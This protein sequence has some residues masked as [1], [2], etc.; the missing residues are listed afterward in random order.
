M[1]WINIV[2][3][4]LLLLCL[5]P[6]PYGY[7]QLV[8]LLATIA[9]AVMAFRYYKQRIMWL[10]Y[11]FGVLALMFQPFYKIA[12][13]R[14]MW[15]IV[16]VIVAVGLTILFFYHRRRDNSIQMEVVV[17]P[18]K[19]LETSVESR[20]VRFTLQGKLGPHDLVYVASE[21][22]KELDNWFETHLK[23]FDRLELACGMHI[24][25]LPVLMRQLQEQSVLRYRAPYLN[26]VEVSRLT[27]GNDF[28]LQ[29]LENPEEKGELIHGLLCA[30]SIH[31]RGDG[32]DWTTNRFYPLSSMSDVPIEQQ[33]NSILSQIWRE[34]SYVSQEVSERYCRR[35]NIKNLEVQS[36]SSREKRHLE[37]TGYEPEIE[38]EVSCQYR[39]VKDEDYADNTFNS[40]KE[41]ENTDDLM[42]EIKVRV[43]KLRQRG[44][45]ES[46]LE[47]LLHPD[48]S[49]RRMVITRGYQIMLPDFNNMEIMMEPLVK[50]VYLLFLHHPEGIKFKDLP[51]YRAELTQ[52]YQQLKPGGLTDRAR[53]S[54]EDV[55][56]PLQNSINEK[57]ARIRGAFLREFD[58][59]IA[60]YYYIDGM[61][62]EAKKIALPRELV[63]WE[64]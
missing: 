46:I 33:V 24:V 13:G 40:Q 25:Y 38:D 56:N 34:I 44:I 20:K 16:D 27:V 37:C 29:Y 21:D 8:R 28:L 23:Q 17:P 12:F 49:P 55:T 22:D 47:Q 63:V 58:N 26:D 35:P 18:V 9:F 50:A 30:E 2:L 48:D 51:D 11:T 5:A 62:G 15:N 45:A 4:V 14:T 3:A 19:V 32:K 52:I 43:E 53:K 1:K 54:I 31:R 60:K 36:D 57:C 42:D 10:V 6:M 39:D 7:Y 41:E 59:H 64:R 61:R